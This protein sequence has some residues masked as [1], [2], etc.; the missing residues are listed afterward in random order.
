MGTLN[1]YKIDN[2]KLQDLM[3]TLNQKMQQKGTQTIPEPISETGETQPIRCELYYA[4]QENPV[5]LSWDWVLAAFGQESVRTNPL[6][7]AVLLLK[8]ENGTIYAITFGHA[9]FLYYFQ[10]ALHH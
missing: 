4:Q 7:K 5:S 1:I 10:I 2:D 6:P 3:E 9:F 8:K